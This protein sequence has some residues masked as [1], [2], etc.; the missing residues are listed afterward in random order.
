MPTNLRKNATS[1]RTRFTIHRT[2]QGYWL[3][4]EKGGLVTGVF[5]IQ[6]DALRFALSRLHLRI[7]TV[8]SGRH[9]RA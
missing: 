6:R 1:P 2:T 8:E 4:S 3:A 5:A 7:T 9:D